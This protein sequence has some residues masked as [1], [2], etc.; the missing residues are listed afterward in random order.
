MDIKPI[1]S[2]LRRS[3]TGAILV[4]LQIALA[5]AIMVNSLY[6]IMQRL[7]MIGRDPGIDV[8]NIFFVGWVPSSDNFQGEA[9]MREDLQVLR[10]LPGVVAATTVN[11]MPLSGGGSSTSHVHRARREGP[12][13]RHQLLPGR[14]AGARDLRCEAGRRAATS[15]RRSCASRRATVRRRLPEIIVTRDVAKELFPDES[16]LGKTIYTALATRSRSS[17][18]STTCTARGRAG[19]RSATSRC[20][21]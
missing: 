9:T 7:E 5:L 16:A 1:L 11:A 17:A 10:G 12:A 6:I 15:T 21:R 2:S 14:R 20:S 19:T 8:A 18:S 3:P 4:A 13:R